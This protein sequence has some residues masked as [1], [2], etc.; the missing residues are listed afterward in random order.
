MA[1]A[2]YE[3]KQDEVFCAGPLNLNRQKKKASSIYGL[4]LEIDEK[5]FDAL[6]MLAVCEGEALTFEYIYSIVWSLDS[7]ETA[8]AA[9]KALMEQVAKTG[10]GFM[11]IE[12]ESDRGYAFS[13][14]WSHNWQNQQ[15]PVAMSNEKKLNLD[16]KA[17]KHRQMTAVLFVGAG[18][19]AI[20]LSTAL[21]IPGLYSPND[22]VLLEDNQV[23]LALL[24]FRNEIVFPDMSGVTIAADIAEVT[25]L[26][27]NPNGNPCYFSF[28]ILLAD[29]RETLYISELIAP[30]TEAGTVTLNRPIKAGENNVLLIIRAYDLESLVEIDSH[31]VEEFIIAE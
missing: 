16:V 3:E 1:I 20:I 2:L 28:E 5:T 8:Q 29:T 25:M 24:D 19:M 26:L 22:S 10:H 30:G 27:H 12:Y 11:W 17:K 7:R 14:R 4:E 9:L 23:P 21:M 15:M 31:N 6:D 18:M 13:T